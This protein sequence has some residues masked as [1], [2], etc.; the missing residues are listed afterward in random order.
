MR[1]VIDEINHLFLTKGARQYGDESVSQLAHALQCATLAEQHGASPALI[2]AALLHDI[3]HLLDG[4]DENLARQGIDARHETIGE[5]FLSAHFG[6]AVSRP[7]A[8]HVDAKRYLCA[9]DDGYWDTLSPASKRSLELQGG[10]F[11]ADQAAAFGD[12][13]Y[14]QDAANLRRWDDLAK[15]PAKETLGTDHFAQFLYA[16]HRDA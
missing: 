16:A 2:A 15:D 11:S 5:E 4:G 12:Q 10:I 1:A 3:G 14:A 8:M 13:P 9:V 6:E 7:V